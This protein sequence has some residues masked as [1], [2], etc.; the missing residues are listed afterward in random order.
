MN[1]KSIHQNVK[2]YKRY[3]SVALK[4]DCFYLLL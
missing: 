3:I 4:Y 2:L 1:L